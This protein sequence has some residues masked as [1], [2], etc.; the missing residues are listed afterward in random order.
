MY[1]Y[2]YMCMYSCSGL[3]YDYRVASFLIMHFFASPL[4]VPAARTAAKSRGQVERGALLRLCYGNPL[5]G[6]FNK[7]MG[8]RVGILGQPGIATQGAPLGDGDCGAP[9]G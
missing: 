5:F 9:R 6:S 4:A 1:M 7:V 2:M 8:T 3:S